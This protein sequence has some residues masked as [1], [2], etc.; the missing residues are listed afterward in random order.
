MSGSP[1]PGDWLNVQTGG[2]VR[3]P[4]VT[5]DVSGLPTLKRL[6]AAI[7]AELASLAT[8]AEH[9][10]SA[11]D[12][13][14]LDRADLADIDEPI[15]IYVVPREQ[16]DV[17]LT[18]DLVDSTVKVTIAILMPIPAGESTDDT[19]E[20]LQTVVSDVRAFLDDRTLAAD[21]S[22][23]FRET[24]IEQIY[25]PERLREDRIAEAHLTATYRVIE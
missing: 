13:A 4:E 20:T 16:A 1:Y 10:Q 5:V 17:Q 6:C 19:V 25:N 7:A 23:V 18:R 9:A 22:F 24:T 12:L 8:E 11:V 15:V 14:F 3:L 2:M 21:D